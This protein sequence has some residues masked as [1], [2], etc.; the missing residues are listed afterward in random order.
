M[1]DIAAP[2]PF[3]RILILLLSNKHLASELRFELQGCEFMGVG[4]VCFFS[5]RQDP[6]HKL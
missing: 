4:L 2:S 5:V 1:R 6:I 3:R